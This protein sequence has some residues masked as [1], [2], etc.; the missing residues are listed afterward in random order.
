[1]IKLIL[2]LGLLIFSQ[3]CCLLIDGT[4]Q[5]LVILSRPTGQTMNINGRRFKTPLKVP[6]DRNRNHY[7]I[8]PNGIRVAL[9]KE[10]KTNPN[11]QLTLGWFCVG[12]LPGLVFS[13]IDASTGAANHFGQTEFIYKRGQVLVPY[14]KEVLYGSKWR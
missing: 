10:G 9:T 14:S 7:V 2:I 3:G 6:L 11:F 13:F 12:L 4:T 8:F 1:M 5:D